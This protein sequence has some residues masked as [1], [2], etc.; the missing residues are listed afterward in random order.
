MLNQKKIRKGGILSLIIFISCLLSSNTHALTCS[1]NGLK[2]IFVNGILT[3]PSD[4]N[5]L[6]PTL[7]K[8]FNQFFPTKNDGAVE[9]SEFVK[10]YYDESSK[11]EL[12]DSRYDNDLS[13]VDLD[14][15]Y[16]NTRLLRDFYESL[17]KF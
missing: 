5:K 8:F 4:K 2:I 14:V 7:K 9:L 11:K 17:S 16:N 10:Y 15:F 1:K 3:L 13:A 6:P 12:L